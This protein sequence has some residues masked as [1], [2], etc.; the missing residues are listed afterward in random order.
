MLLE[1]TQTVDKTLGALPNMTVLTGLQ[2]QDQ[3]GK[4]YQLPAGHKLA[5]YQYPDDHLEVIPQLRSEN[6]YELDHRYILTTLSDSLTEQKLDHA[7]WQPRLYKQS[8]IMNCNLVLDVEYKV[9]EAP[10][11]V[12]QKLWYGGQ[13]LRRDLLGKYHPMISITNS[14][15]A[16]SR[17]EFGIVRIICGNGMVDTMFSQVL[18]FMHLESICATFKMR[19]EE[20]IQNVLQYQSIERFIEALDSRKILATVFLAMMLKAAGKRVTEAADKKYSITTS[21]EL[22][23]WVA[24]NIA[25]YCATHWVQGQDAKTRLTNMMQSYGDSEVLQLDQGQSA[26]AIT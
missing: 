4:T 13:R 14:F 3:L 21:G 9:D 7:V 12:E 18:R 20:L 10:F 6:Y 22:S 5:A 11:E 26:K 16:S 2:G 19:C 24:Y 25:T 15:F 17:I 1:G 23:V 8:G